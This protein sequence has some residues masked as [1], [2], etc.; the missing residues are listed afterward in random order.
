[1]QVSCF[2]FDWNEVRKRPNAGA[3][4]E[5]MI[6]TDDIDNY[7]TSLPEEMWRSDSY[8]QHFEAAEGLSELAKSAK[9]SNREA[10]ALVA[11]LISTG[12]S[13]DELGLGPLTDGC[14][15]VSISPERV[16][17][18]DAAFSSID[19]PNLG[20]LCSE[21]KSEAA[22]DLVAWLTQWRDAIRYVKERGLGL[23]GHCG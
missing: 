3:I 2:G 17:T 16:A 13:I 15:F 19:L 1:M 21:S 20:E 12:E 4:V 9:A 5:E 8:T 14:Y 6:L 22:S 11:Q 23:I 10:I 7:A 18:L